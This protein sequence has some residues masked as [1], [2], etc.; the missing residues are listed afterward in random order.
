MS[1][2][3][4][5]AVIGAGG[6]G[7]MG[8]LRST[9]NHLNTIVFLGD[10][11]TTRKSRATWV[12]S[13][14][15]IPGMFD[16][17]HPITAT[18]REVIQFIEGRRDLAPFLT[19]VKQ[20]VKEIS[21]KRDGFILK[22]QDQMFQASYVVLCT[23]TMDIQPKISGSIKPILPYANREDIFYCIRCDGHK[24]VGKKCAVIGDGAHAGWIAIMLKERYALPQLWVLTNGKPF[25]G[26][27]EVN[28]LLEKYQ[29]GVI[30]DPI[31]EIVGDPKIGL[32]GF[33]IKGKTVPATKAFVALGSI[34][35]ND[36]AKQLGV[37]L[38]KQGYVI[39]SETYE[40]SV[41]GFYAAGDLVSGKK[42]Q[43]YTAWD[44]S[45]DAVDDI[46]RKIRETKRQ[47]YLTC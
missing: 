17:K 20:S 1:P 30:E 33:Q 6:A 22:T 43:V 3:F 12:T 11:E 13:V 8:M 7:Q 45:V 18:T 37:K 44:M 14:N 21:E 25:R 28:L 41:K 47:A 24:V 35:Y 36:L 4:D 29:I 34:V 27:S 40:T 23:G 9:L 38:D 39:T 2:I 26:S 32:G 46:D 15:N 31:D 42:K 5:V 10:S 16:K 19:L